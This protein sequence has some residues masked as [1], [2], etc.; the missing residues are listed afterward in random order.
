MQNIEDVVEMGEDLDE[1]HLLRSEVR[2]GINKVLRRL[3]EIPAI[4]QIDD[5]VFEI[6]E[7]LLERV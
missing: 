2:I 7:K 3:S 5:E 1:Y 4:G 6:L